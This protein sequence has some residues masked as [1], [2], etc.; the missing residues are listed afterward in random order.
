MKPL[1][2]KEAEQFFKVKQGTGFNW[3]TFL[4]VMLTLMF[5][6][7]KL[8][9]F[10]TMSWLWVFSPLWIPTAIALVLIITVLIAYAIF[11]RNK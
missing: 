10:S 9:K 7:A 1:T 6:A 3:T 2:K 11:G 4:C 8:F 5:A